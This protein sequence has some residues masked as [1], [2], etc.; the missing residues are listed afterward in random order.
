MSSTEVSTP[1]TTSVAS[2]R[3]LS[4]P[5]DYA[6]F[7]QQSKET[8]TNFEKKIGN[9]GLLDRDLYVEDMQTLI[10]AFE[11]RLDAQLED[12]KIE[13]S[14]MADPLPQELS[15]SIKTG[16]SPNCRSDLGRQYRECI[17]NVKLSGNEPPVTLQRLLDTY[18][19]HHKPKTEWVKKIGDFCA[20]FQGPLAEWARKTRGEKNWQ[21][22]W[23][24]YG[25]L[26]RDLQKRYCCE[27]LDVNIS[28][29]DFF[30]LGPYTL[31]TV[32]VDEF[33]ELVPKVSP[34]LL[35]RESLIARFQTLLPDKL[36]RESYDCCYDDWRE[37]KDWAEYKLVVLDG[38]YGWE[39]QSG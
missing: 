6:I 23:W 3:S 18:E 31:F 12:F 36:R 8:L 25:Q 34:G 11:T 35:A 37:V 4:P 24:T 17:C 22:T 7:C 30:T 10:D 29:R 19:A 33:E 39:V 1:C 38:Q 2:L 5:P 14:S 26:K 15:D 27:N 28:D 32:L 20:C 21:Q 13:L 16:S 9:V